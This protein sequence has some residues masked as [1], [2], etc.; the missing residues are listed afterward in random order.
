MT[1]TARIA[2]R[3]RV[4]RRVWRRV[5]IAAGVLAAI[6]VLAVGAL[7]ASAYRDPEPRF[8]E[9]RSHLVDVA[10]TPAELIEDHWVHEARLTA[11]SGL[12]VSLL[13][14]RPMADSADGGDWPDSIRRSR[15][16]GSVW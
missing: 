2:T 4:W 1:A 10:E 8:A 13:V 9:R 16:S 5:G 6:V 3:R 15:R 12:Q 11:A 7:V 14:K